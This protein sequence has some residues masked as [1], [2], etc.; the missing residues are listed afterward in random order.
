M[1]KIKILY[2]VTKC[3]KCGPINVLLNIVDYMDLDVFDLYLITTSEEDA[4]RSIIGAFKE[5]AIE[6]IF[7]P[8]DSRK[9][10]VG[11]TGALRDTIKRISP[12]VVHSTGIV[13]D[14]AVSKICPEKQ[15]I[16]SHANVFVDN[17]LKYG[18]ILGAFLARLNIYV[19]KKAKLTIACSKSLSI[20]YRKYGL[21]IPF[22]RNGVELEGKNIYDKKQLRDELG[23]PVASTIFVYAATF[24]PR[25]NHRFLI[26]TFKNFLPECTLLL[27]G[28][29][30]L[31]QEMESIGG[32]NII[33]V[34]RKQNVK[35]YYMASDYFVSSSLQEGMPMAVLEG[36]ACGLP[37]LLSDIEQHK[38]L[39]EL[40]R[41]I[42]DLFTN[43]SPDSLRTAC[44]V[45]M[46]KSYKVISDAAFETVE[47]FFNAQKMSAEYQKKYKEIAGNR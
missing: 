13:P 39:F 22:I 36:M 33:F 29:G 15:L 7:V 6:H 27:L 30:E 28:D 42:G 40:G 11:I 17:E 19:Y 25:K 14:L 9:V 8:L 21:N 10:L 34:G 18:K 26:E 41:D 43:G 12:D 23:L 32:N 2:V 35:P 45:L 38:E 5:K 46:K 4:G 24:I 31:F 16:I 3:T 37:V 1:E 20:L 47:E 44:N